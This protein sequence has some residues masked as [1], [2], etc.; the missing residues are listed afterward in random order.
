MIPKLTINTIVHNKYKILDVL[1]LVVP[2]M[3]FKHISL[4]FK[5]SK[6]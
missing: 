2:S 5:S 6:I 1:C 3:S 4:V